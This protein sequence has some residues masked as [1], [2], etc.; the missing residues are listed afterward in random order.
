MKKV[1]PSLWFEHN[2]KD[3]F[4][5]YTHVFEDIKLIDTIKLHQGSEYETNVLYF[6]LRDTYFMAM[7]NGPFKMHPSISFMYEFNPDVDQTALEKIKKTYNLLK[8]GGKV[9]DELQ[10]TEFAKL[11]AFVTDKFG[12]SWHLALRSSDTYK[13][14]TP[15]MS[16]AGSSYG[17]ANEGINLYKKV[18]KDVTVLNSDFADNHKLRFS[19]FNLFNHRFVAMDVNADYKTSEALSFQITCKDQAEMDAYFD[20]LSYDKN[21]EACG[22]IKDRY[23]FSWQIVPEFLNHLTFNG[24]KDEQ[25]KV[26]KV[27]FTMKK[28]ILDEMM[29]ALKK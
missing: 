23:G 26:F 11:Y 19:D 22:W 12:L 21:A 2:V 25:D 5:Y 13:E 17:K 4:E 6:T 29:N 15:V 9:I 14:V 24:S 1:V 7:G 10:E 20:P 16:F 8:E 28:L 18:F 3:V 27:V